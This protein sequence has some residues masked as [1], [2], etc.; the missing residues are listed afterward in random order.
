VTRSEREPGRDMKNKRG[1]QN[2]PADGRRETHFRGTP[3]VRD[4]VIGLSDGLTVPF[5]LAAGVSAAVSNAHLVV[6]VGLAEIAAGSISMGLGGY[7]VASTESEHYRAEVGRET[8][9]TELAPEL[10]AQEVA[11]ILES[12]G[13]PPEE[14]APLVRSI[15]ADR[16]RWIGFMMRFEIGLDEP[17]PSRIWRSALT[18]ALSYV[19]GGLIPLIPYMIASTVRTAL[20]FSALVTVLALFGFGYG[21]NRIIGLSP[22]RGA[23]Q[24]VLIGGVAAGAAF[25]IARLVT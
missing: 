23:I 22:L 18:I 15:R 10:E 3:A 8:K 20:L 11:Q 21:K 13:L 16:S 9:E 2:I 14:V 19:A 17:N 25:L 4:V 5:A 24:T 12:Y 7:L 6:A 1:G